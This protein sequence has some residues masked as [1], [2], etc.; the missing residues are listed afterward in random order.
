MPALSA[1]GRGDS[2]ASDIER[3]AAP[4]RFPHRAP[5]SP[6]SCKLFRPKSF[7]CTR[8]STTA[9]RLCTSQ[10]GAALGPASL[11]PLPTGDR[12]MSPRGLASGLGVTNPVPLR[13]PQSNFQDRAGLASS[14]F[15]VAACDSLRNTMGPGKRECFPVIFAPR[16]Q[17]PSC[18]VQEDASPRQEDERAAN[19]GTAANPRAPASRGGNFPPVWMQIGP[20]EGSRLRL[21]GRCAP[22]APQGR[23]PLSLR[24]AATQ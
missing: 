9:S 20:L 10:P 8:D 6:P 17:P 14:F 7:H 23:R 24:P 21:T 15:V 19:A 5:R 4:K 1:G 22:A 11:A 12:R 2:K 3:G 16:I 13:S 18:I